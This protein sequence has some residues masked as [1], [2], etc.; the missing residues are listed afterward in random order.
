MMVV[1][2]QKQKV[3]K[4]CHQ[5]ENYKNSLKGNQLEHKIKHLEKNNIDVDHK[6]IIKTIN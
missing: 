4:V 3:Q 2:I 5:F 6:E 1:K